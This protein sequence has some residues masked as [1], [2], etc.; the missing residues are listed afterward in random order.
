[1][2]VYKTS[3]SGLLTRR[4]YTS[5][6]AGNEQFIPFAPSGAYDSIATVDLSGGAASSI[7]FSS[8]PQTYTHLQLRFYGR[9]TNAGTGTSWQRW[10]INGD[11]ATTS[12]ARH[13][14][15]YSVGDGGIVVQASDSASTFGR[16]AFLAAKTGNTNPFYTGAICDFLDYTNTTKNKVIRTFS[17][18]TDNGGQGTIGISS[19]VWLNTGAITSINLT[20]NNG[21]D[22]SQYTHVGLYGIKGA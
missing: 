6:L 14:L 15:V 20:D 3:N 19:T 7:T 21:F 2:A 1:M 8:I 17:G 22:Y 16:L 12:Y 13:L 9:V 5:F 4:E 18:G 11:T 10:A